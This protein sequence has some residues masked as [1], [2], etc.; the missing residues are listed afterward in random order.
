MQQQGGSQYGVPPPEMVPPFTSPMIGI[1]TGVEY[2]QQSSQQVAEDASPINSR[3]APPQP[4]QQ[5]TIF[6]EYGSGGGAMVR[7]FA[8]EEALGAG[9]ES[10]RGG[11][12]GNRWPRQEALALLKIRSDMD[13]VFRDAT[14]KGPLWE[15]VSRKL[16]ELGYSRSA[17]KCKEKF[18]NVHKY[19]K[20]TK[21]GRAG[22]QDGKSYRFFTQLEALHGSTGGTT[23]V[24]SFPSPTNTTFIPNLTSAAGS[25]ASQHKTPS[26]SFPIPSDS[27]MTPPPPVTRSQPPPVAAPAPPSMPLLEIST[28]AAVV[29]ISFSSN[30]SSSSASESD[31]E[32]TEEGGLGALHDGGRKRKREEWPGGSRKMIAFFDGLMKQVMERQEA[33]QQRFLET[34]EKREQDR[35]IREEAWKRQEMARLNREYELMAQERTMAANRDAAIISFLQKFTGIQPPISAATPPEESAPPPPTSPVEQPKPALAPAVQAPAMQNEASDNLPIERN[36]LLLNQATSSSEP[37]A[38]MSEMADGMGVGSSLDAISPSSSS[39]RWPKMEVLALIKLRSGLE[40][41]YLESGP[42][43]PLW[44]EIS[45]GMKRLGYNRNSKRCK[46]KWENINKYFKKVKESNK[47]RPED[48]KTCPY[49]HELDALYRK[50]QLFGGAA[51]VPSGIAAQ[52]QQELAINQ[53]IG[54]SLQTQVQLSVLPEKESNKV[55]KTP[56]TLRN[57]DGGNH[58]SSGIQIARS[59][60]TGIL[61][62]F[63][64]EEP[65]TGAALPP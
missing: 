29:G 42:K 9:E 48:A 2:L 58:E 5:V 30:T 39:S 33:M 4:R 47:K 38:A 41:R 14:L 40:S 32:N 35:M 57:S 49:F 26:S 20:R 8:D 64:L 37:A 61:L 1:P 19:Y 54:E 21:E 12:G 52:Q 10:E 22:R 36:D 60:G 55:Q 7:N 50:K 59:N 23:S 28:P 63:S 15:D 45:L 17:K 46:E 31:G 16:A 13:A 24:N 3:P 27:T 53:K 25:A 44:E 6:E 56:N 43:G 34:I 62:K 18:E 11:G 65:Q 51:A